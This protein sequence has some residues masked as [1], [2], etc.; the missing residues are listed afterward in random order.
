MWGNGVMAS[1]KCSKFHIK[2]DVVIDLMF[3]RYIHLAVISKFA[4]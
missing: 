1:M 2:I 3:Q 4:I